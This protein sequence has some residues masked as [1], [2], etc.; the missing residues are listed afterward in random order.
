MAAGELRARD[1]VIEAEVTWG[2]GVWVDH[3][4]YGMG[5]IGGSLGMADPALGLAEAYVTRRMGD[6]ERADALDAAVRAALA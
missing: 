1:P 4:G 3:D 6:H 5:G 2:L